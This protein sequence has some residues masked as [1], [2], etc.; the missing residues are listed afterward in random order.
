MAGIVTD[1][2]VTMID[3]TSGIM[4]LGFSRLSTISNLVAN[5]ALSSFTWLLYLILRSAAPFFVTLAQQG[6]LDYPLFGLSLTRN[7]S[8]TLSIGMSAQRTKCL[9]SILINS[10]AP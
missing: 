4:G 5:S 8:G 6:L 7:A 2:D 9:L 10:Q 1:C 3:D